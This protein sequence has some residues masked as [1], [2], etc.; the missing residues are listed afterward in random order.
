MSNYAFA[1]RPKWI[2]G[3]ILAVVAIV[4]FVSMG[5]W[6]LRRLADR[7]DFNALLTSRAVAEAQPLGAI[8]DSSFVDAA[9]V[10]LQRVVATGE[11]A[12]GEELMLLARSFNGLSGHHVLTPLYLGDGTAVIVDRGWVNIDQDTP[13]RSEFAPPAGAVRVEGVLRKTETRGSFGPVDPATGTLERIARVDL[14]RIDQQVDAELLPVYIQLLSQDP[15]QADD[16]PAIVGL[17]T[18]SEGPHRGYAVQWFLF[19]GVVVVGYPI[20]LRKTAGS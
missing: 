14:E 12:V 8:V 9:E 17:P 16:I 7:Q 6:Q 18:P 11:Y 4:V 1:R 15:P 5:F 19:A 20:L 10:E 2:A 3:H 13:G